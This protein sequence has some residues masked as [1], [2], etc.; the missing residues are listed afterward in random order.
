MVQNIFHRLSKLFH[1]FS[2]IESHEVS[3]NFMKFL[4]SLKNY[5]LQSLFLQIYPSFFN[6]NQIALAM[7]PNKFISIC[8]YFFV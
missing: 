6:Q 7:Y 8:S 5:K 2:M 3:R 4:D 1:K